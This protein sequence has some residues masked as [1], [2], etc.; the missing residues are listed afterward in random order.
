MWFDV[1]HG[2]LLVNKCFWETVFWRQK[3]IVFEKK[4]MKM[5]RYVYDF[6]RDYNMNLE[7]DYKLF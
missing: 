7:S 2:T 6:R 5:E 3:I 4:I 1:P